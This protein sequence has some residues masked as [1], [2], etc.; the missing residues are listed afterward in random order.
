MPDPDK[1][2]PDS[3]PIFPRARNARLGSLLI[4][5]MLVLFISNMSIFIVGLI[6][7]NFYCFRQA[8]SEVSELYLTYSSL[9]E[10][11]YRKTKTKVITLAERLSTVYILLWPIITEE[12]IASQ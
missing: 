8:I 3:P 2:L 6:D 5:A 11:I 1:L 10:K 9:T 4:I 12:N 7:Y